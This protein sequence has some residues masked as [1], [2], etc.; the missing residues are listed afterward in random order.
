MEWQLQL[1]SK[2]LHVTP[3]TCSANRAGLRGRVVHGSVGGANG[4]CRCRSSL[5]L[6][7]YIYTAGGRKQ[8]AEAEADLQSW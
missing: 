1:P 5:V 7:A 6:L 8:E 2:A 3:A 4:T